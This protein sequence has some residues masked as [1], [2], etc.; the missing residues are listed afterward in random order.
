MEI[1]PLPLL[2]IPLEKVIEFSPSRRHFLLFFFF[3]F[4]IFEEGSNS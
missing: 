2:K 3:F 4:L 1:V